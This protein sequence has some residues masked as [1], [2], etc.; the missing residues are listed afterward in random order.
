[1]PFLESDLGYVG[2][3]RKTFIIFA[4]FDYEMTIYLPYLESGLGY[5][6]YFRKTFI[7]FA[8]Y[9]HEIYFRSNCLA[10]LHVKGLSS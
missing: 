8:E 6:E 2:Y 9:N 7:I 4:K 1:M 3:F 5:V 10:L